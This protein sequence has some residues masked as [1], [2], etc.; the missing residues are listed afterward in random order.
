M[1]WSA[2]GSGAQALRVNAENSTETPLSAGATFTGS[3]VDCVAVGAGSLVVSAGTDSGVAGEVS[4]QFSRDGSTVSGTAGPWPFVSGSIGVPKAAVTTARYFR[5]VVENTDASDQ[6]T[7]SVQ[8]LIRPAGAVAIPTSRVAQTQSDYSDCLSVRLLTDVKLD[9]SRGLHTGRTVVHKFGA[10][11]SVAAATQECITD[12]GGIYAG[13]LT[14]AAPVRI[15]AGGDANDDAAGTGARAVEIVGLDE[16]GVGFTESLAT[17]GASASSATSANVL[18][19]FRAY[20]TDSGTYG[21][22]N[23][24]EIVLET[25]GGIEVA[26]IRRI[27]AGTNDS[28]AGQTQMAIYTVPAGKVAYVRHLYANVESAKTGDVYFWQRR[29]ATTT[30]APF[31]APRT[32]HTIQGLSGSEDYVPEAPFGPFPA[33]TDLFVTGVGPTGGARISAR[34]EIVI[35]DAVG[36]V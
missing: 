35:V 4:V 32:Y 19:V 12:G 17:A 26:R 1:V 21:G 11:P 8:T 25:T 34:M 15:K 7:L 29:D 5:V 16:N 3:W 9:E 6:T 28:G 2:G 10:N 30:S 23:A 13:F 20:V 18:R 27:G 14:T 36:E 33:L 31:T 22:A 24:A